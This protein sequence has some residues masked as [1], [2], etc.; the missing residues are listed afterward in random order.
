MPFSSLTSCFFDF[1]PL[2]MASKSRSW[3]ATPHSKKR[4]QE[5][6]VERLGEVDR[7]PLLMRVDP[8]DLVAEVLVLAADV[9]VGVVDVVVR[10]L[11]RLGGRCGVPVPGRR[12]DLGVVH[13]VPLAVE[14]VVADLHVLEDLGRRVRGRA[15]H[16]GGPVA[17][18]EQQHAARARRAGGASRSS[19]RCSGGRGRRGPRRPRRGSRRTRLPSSSICSALSR[20][21]GLSISVAGL[22]VVTSAPPRFR[23]R[24][25]RRPR[26]R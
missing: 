22:A 6:V 24:S 16:P 9:R 26:A 21:S 17:R 4:H 18:A 10:V 11:P 5:Q 20:A 2:R 1:S 7:V 25:R 14:D 19:R 13:P 8:H 15:G 12:V 23:A 3:S